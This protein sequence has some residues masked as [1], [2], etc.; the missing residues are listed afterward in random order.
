[1]CCEFYLDCYLNT[2]IFFF[3]FLWNKDQDSL[4]KSQGV[5]P[6]RKVLL[7]KED[8][9]GLGISIT[10]RSSTSRF[11]MDRGLVEPGSFG[12]QSVL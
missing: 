12:K 9:E 6:I 1:M 11:S 5:G 8:H 2:T 10:V 3:F 7:L 4:K